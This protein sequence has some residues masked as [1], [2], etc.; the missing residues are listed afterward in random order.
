MLTA[1]CH[2]GRLVELR[3]SGTPT[4]EDAL[5]FKRDAHS[6]I[7]QVVR[8]TKRKIV[9]CSDLRASHLFRPE[10]TEELINTMKGANPHL[11]R[12]GMLGSGS[13]LLSLQLSRFINEAKAHDDRRRIFTQPELVFHFLDEVLAPGERRRLRD[14]IGELD[15]SRL[16]PVIPLHTM[17]SA[18]EEPSYTRPARSRRP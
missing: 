16:P 12:N 10:V 7:A 9:V 11:E 18:D 1:Q 13:A 4:L 6:C 5:N 2:E 14:F 15:T 17:S 3:L 8:D